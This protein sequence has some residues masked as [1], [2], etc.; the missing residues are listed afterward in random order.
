[1]RVSLTL[2]TDIPKFGFGTFGDTHLYHKIAYNLSTGN[3]YSG[4]DDGQ[5]YGNSSQDKKTIYSPV[6]TRGPVYPIFLY[7]MYN[8]SGNPNKISSLLEWGLIL[9][10]V[11]IVQCIL[12]SLLAVLIFFFVRIIYPY[13]L[14]PA[15]FSSM[16]YAFSFYHIYYT[17]MLL[18]ECITSVLVFLS[19]FF[20]LL[21]TKY[22]KAF[23]WC[24]SGICLGFISLCRP[25]YILFPFFIAGF[26]F[27]KFRK[28]RF[29]FIL[30]LFLGL[31]LSIT[32]WS[33]R[34]L[35]VFHEM[36][37]LAV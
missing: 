19:L 28:Q 5:A 32:P 3:G 26:I 34:N 11:R 36:N 8:L 33:V 31:V 25:E 6:I 29:K 15:I 21:S 2:L 24:I 14:A 23:L 4:I 13:H 37:P 16:L 9:R 35:I 1:M 10:N 17:R 7:Y 30:L 20:I 22:K 12:D 27:F 18:T